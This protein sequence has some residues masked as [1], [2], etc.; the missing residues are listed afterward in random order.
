MP[1]DYV[2]AG[3]DVKRST[4]GSTTTSWNGYSAT[5]RT[6]AWRASVRIGLLTAVYTR[7]IAVVQFSEHI[8]TMALMG[9]SCACK[10]IGVL[11]RFSLSVHVPI[12]VE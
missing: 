12:F 3:G 9:L 4:G 6:G 10:R 5:Y 8:Q 7:T 11:I 1:P 2:V